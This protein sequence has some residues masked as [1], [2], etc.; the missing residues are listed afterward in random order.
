MSAMRSPES[1]RQIGVPRKSGEVAEGE[2]GLLEMEDGHG[3]VTVYVH[4][5]G[6]RFQLSGLHGLGSGS[7]VLGSR[8]EVRVHG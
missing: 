1:I 7:P 3:G 4:V 6:S 2:M 8:F 5:H